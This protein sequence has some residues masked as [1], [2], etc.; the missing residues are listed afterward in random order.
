MPPFSSSL[1]EEGVL[2]RAFLLARNGVYSEEELRRMLTSGAYPSRSPEDNLADIRAQAAANKIGADLLEH[3]VVSHGEKKVLAYM[4]FIRDAAAAKVRQSLLKIHEGTHRFE[5]SLDDGSK[6]A[7]SVT[8]KHGPDGG[9]A[10]V[11]FTGTGPTSAGNLNA[12]PAIVRS[13]VLYCFRCLLAEDVPLNDGVLAPVTIV[14]PEGTI[15]SPIADADPAKCPAVVGG[16]VETSQ[17]VVDVVF[18]AIGAA[19]ASQG[20]MNNFLFG[21][22]LGEGKAGFGY[23]ETICGGS[24]A[25]P[26]TVG[27]DA[28]HTHMTNTRITDPEVLE[29]RYPVRLRE[30]SIRRGSGGDGRFQGGDGVI[31]EFEFLDA[32]EVSM[33]TNR[34]TTPPFGLLG[35]GPGRAGRNLLQRVGESAWTELPSAA[36]IEVQRGDVLRLE[37]PGGGACGAPLAAPRD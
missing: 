12:N 34:R 31:R 25:T 37:T 10:L 16:N 13:A 27:A 36:T 22:K 4:A 26:N 17:R 14:I 23:Y 33:L 18:G 7:V 3:L 5:D 32:L 29:D 11:D 30:F 6:I 20:T 2:I 21:R 24:G 28:V 9:E 1:A 35:G 8:I 19:A 15:L